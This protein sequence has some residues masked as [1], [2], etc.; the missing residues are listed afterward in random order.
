MVRKI[1]NVGD[2]EVSSCPED[3]VARIAAGKAKWKTVIAHAG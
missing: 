3:L 2:F 1:G